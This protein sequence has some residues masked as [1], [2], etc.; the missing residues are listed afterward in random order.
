MANIDFPQSPIAG[1]QFTVGSTVWTWDGTKWTVNPGVLGIPD[2]P[3]VGGPYGRK[4]VSGT[5]SWSEIGSGGVASDAPPDGTLYGRENSS[6]QHITHTDITDWT[7]TLAPY[8]LVT[9]VP[10]VTTLTPLV[11]GTAAVG[12]D[13]GWARGDHIHPTDTTRYAASNPAGYQTAAQVT[14]ALGAYLPLAGGTLTGGLTGV[15]ASFPSGI[16]VGGFTN[17]N[18]FTF[19]RAQNASGNAGFGFGDEGGNYKG[20]IY[21]E[22]GNTIVMSNA[23]GGGYVQVLNNNQIWL[24]GTTTVNGSL[25]VNTDLSVARDHFSDMPAGTPDVCYRG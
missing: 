12:I 11:N 17:T 14:G 13:T 21:W 6:W 23:T 5:M 19:T 8:A 3:S 9:S 7:A 22:H 15:N 20:Q 24:S 2:A 25:T 18:G 10:L 16:T 4:L 1:Q